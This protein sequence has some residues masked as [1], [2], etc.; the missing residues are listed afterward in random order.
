MIVSPILLGNE[1]WKEE[2]DPE[3]DAN[4]VEIAHNLF[5]EYKKIADEKGTSL[6][7]AADYVQPSDA[8]QE[9]LTED[10]HKILAGVIYNT[11]VGANIV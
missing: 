5:G 7:S 9:H 6:I 11:L 4:S 10:G 8:D 1:V 2:Y 3:F